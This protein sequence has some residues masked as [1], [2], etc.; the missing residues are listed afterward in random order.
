MSISKIM[1]IGTTSALLQLVV[2]IGYAISTVVW[3][4]RSNDIK[5]IFMAFQQSPLPVFLTGDLPLLVLVGLYIGTFP[6]LY[7]SLRKVSPTIALICTLGT[8]LGVVIAFTGESTFALWHLSKEYAS[9]ISLNQKE[10]IIAAGQAV[11]ATGWWNSTASYLTGILLQGTGTIICVVMLHTNIFHKITAIS[12][13]L[14]NSLDLFQHLFD[15][16]V[17]GIH[18]TIAPIMGPFYLVWLPML[19]WDFWRIQ[20]LEVHSKSGPKI[21]SHPTHSSKY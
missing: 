6:A 15:P 18:E 11:I 5:E 13:I 3:G 20:R 19:A 4:G 2:I 17:P 1:R 10:M 16:F 21:K 9:A 8:L 7:F 14:A 12:G